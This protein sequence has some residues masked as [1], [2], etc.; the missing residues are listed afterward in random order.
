MEG[1]EEGG[2]DVRGGRESQGWER[3]S[4]IWRGEEG[5]AHGDAFCDVND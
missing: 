2:V 4:V 3:I 5:G 1:G